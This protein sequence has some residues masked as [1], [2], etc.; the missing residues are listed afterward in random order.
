MMSRFV[1]GLAAVLT[2]SAAASAQTLGDVA[3]Q[4]EARRKTVKAPAK[5]YT[6]DSLRADPSS[7]RPAAAGTPGSPASSAGSAA[8]STPDASQ[9]AGTPAP[10]PDASAKDEASWKRRMAA[11]R[12]VVERAKIFADALQ[13][14]INSLSNDWAAR[15]DPYQRN[16]IAADRDKALAELSRVQKEVQDGTKA[17]AAIQ[18]EARKA[19]VPA[20]WVR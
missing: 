2:I 16:K 20:G 3:R 11:A 10:A 8:P 12:E 19:G 4:E 6:N 17:I 9:Q 1:V 13:T 15:D 14:R 18:E 5:V 7:P